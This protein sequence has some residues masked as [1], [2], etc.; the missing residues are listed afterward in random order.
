MLERIVGVKL[1][2]GCD[3]VPD[4]RPEAAEEETDTGHASTANSDDRAHGDGS[5]CNTADWLARSSVDICHN[6]YTAVDTRENSVA[7]ALGVNLRRANGVWADVEIGR[8]GHQS[9]RR[10][11]LYPSTSVFSNSG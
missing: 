5:C 2:L 6:R 10:R 9:R 4:R 1:N 7:D 11:Q 3:S 8:P